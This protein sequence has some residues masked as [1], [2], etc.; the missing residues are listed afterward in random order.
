MKQIFVTFASQFEVK[1]RAIIG[2]LGGI[3]NAEREKD[4][5]SYYKSLTG[6]VRH[7]EG[8][9]PA[10]V[11]LVQQSL[12]DGSA[13]KKV[14]FPLGKSIPEGPLGDSEWKA[15][16]E[17]T[18]KADAALVEFVNKLTKEE[19][20]G[21]AKWFSGD[22]VTVWYILCTL[23]AH[24]IHHQGQIS[25]ILDEMHIENNFSGIDPAFAK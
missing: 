15:L 2:L 18:Q 21:S 4:R 23:I 19:L 5:G 6:L 13:A 16:V 10:F 22:S 20:A 14:S 12:G 8:T 17:F 11:N 24:Y 9:M 25:Q 3:S 1:N 7:Y